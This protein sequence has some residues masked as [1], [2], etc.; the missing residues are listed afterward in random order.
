MFGYYIG[1][2]LMDL[3]G[4]KIIGIYGLMEDYEKISNLYNRYDALAVFIAGV[5]PLPYKIA[6][7]SAG[8]FKINFLTFAIVSIVSRGLRFFAVAALIYF[9]GTKIKVF[10][11]KYFNLLAVIF[12]ILLIGGFLISKFIF[13]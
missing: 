4:F 7:I 1:W 13:E 6:T 11:D 8:A 3:I 2:Q 9:F 12:T 5:T 10:I